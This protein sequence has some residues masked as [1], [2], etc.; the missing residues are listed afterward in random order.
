MI[1]GS[2]FFVKRETFGS[3]NQ[4]L[5]YRFDLVL[6]VLTTKSEVERAWA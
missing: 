1:L 5:L 2:I 4:L 6:F 3:N